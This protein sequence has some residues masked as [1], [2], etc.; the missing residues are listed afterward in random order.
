VGRTLVALLSLVTVGLAAREAV[1]RAAWRNAETA[2]DLAAARASL[3]PDAG[4]VALPFDAGDVATLRRA[5]VLRPRDPRLLSALAEAA[6]DP[7]APAALALAVRATVVAPYSGRVAD[8]TTAR[9][10]AAG[11]ARAAT[12]VLWRDRARRAAASGRPDREEL[13]REAERSLAGAREVLEAVL[14]VDAA[15]SPTTPGRAPVTER[16]DAARRRL[17]ELEETP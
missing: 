4:L 7:L 8:A 1:G 10:L 15:L 6:E 14:A 3:L 5:L 9:L 2:A 12:A 13:E 17:A 16:A 11:E